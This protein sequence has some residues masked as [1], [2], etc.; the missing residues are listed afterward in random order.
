[1]MKVILDEKNLSFNKKW[2]AKIMVNLNKN[3]NEE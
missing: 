2:R 1:M 3:G